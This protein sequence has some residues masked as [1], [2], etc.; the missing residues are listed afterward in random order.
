MCKHKNEMNLNA[1]SEKFPF[2]GVIREANLGVS[3]RG[4]QVEL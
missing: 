4:S 3:L 2:Q 1:K